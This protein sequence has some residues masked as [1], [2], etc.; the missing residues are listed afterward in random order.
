[1]G[2]TET[3]PLE[4]ITCWTAISRTFVEN[5]CIWIIPGSHKQGLQKHTRDEENSELVASFTGEEN[6]IPVEMAPGQIAI[7]SS[8]MLHKSGANTSGEVRHGYVPQYHHP[9]VIRVNT[10]EPFGDRYPVLRN[11]NPV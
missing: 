7:F 11:G 2:Y 6:A 5:G 4:Y 3:D 1:S 8:L 10:G 9:G